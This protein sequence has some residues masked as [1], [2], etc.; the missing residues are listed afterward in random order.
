MRRL[1]ALATLAVA[2]AATPSHAAICVG[3]AATVHACLNRDVTV[4]PTGGPVSHSDC[5]VVGDPETCYPVGFSSPNAV[6]T[7]SG[8]VVTTECAICEN[9]TIQEAVDTVTDTATDIVNRCGN[10][11]LDWI[12]NPTPLREPRC[13]S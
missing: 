10:G 3:T 13:N 7:G 12:E 6:V 8:S 4:T 5:V 2:A 9:P 1:L 11:I